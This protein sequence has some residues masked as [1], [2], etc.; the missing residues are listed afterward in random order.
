MDNTRKDFD[1]VKVGDVVICYDEYQHDY[2]EHE[3]LVTSIEDD[4]ADVCEGN[5]LG[6]R[7]YGDDT[8]DENDESRISMVHPGN[9]VSIRPVPTNADELYEYVHDYFMN[10]SVELSTAYFGINVRMREKDILL[11]WKM[12]Q[13][14]LN[15]DYVY[16]DGDGDGE[17]DSDEDFIPEGEYEDIYEGI[18][19]EFLNNF[20]DTRFHR[21][22]YPGEEDEE[23]DFIY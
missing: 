3:M 17:N 21:K 19:E 23:F 13:E 16:R 7:L 9:F 11:A 10:S 4:K 14:D 15:G 20:K 2:V 8:T 12:A 18:A 22:D 6:R 5:L 1:Q